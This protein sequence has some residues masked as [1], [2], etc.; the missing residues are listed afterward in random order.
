KIPNGREL[1]RRKGLFVIDD[2]NRL[3]EVVVSAMQINEGQDAAQV[4][5]SWDGDTNIV[6]KNALVDLVPSK[7]NQSL[8]IENI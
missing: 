3:G 6:V 4:L 1:F 7:K 5:S 8:E 2:W